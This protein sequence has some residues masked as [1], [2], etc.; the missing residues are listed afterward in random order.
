VAPAVGI[1][2]QETRLPDEVVVVLVYGEV[3]DGFLAWQRS[4]RNHPAPVPLK[5][6][7]LISHPHITRFDPGGLRLAA[8]DPEGM[9]SAGPERIMFALDAYLQ[10]RVLVQRSERRDRL[11][12]QLAGDRVARDDLVAHLDLFN[13][14]V[15]TVGTS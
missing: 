8:F 13:R 12:F 14:N 6:L 3:V 5:G 15:A 2:Y 11:R 4:D 1:V 9:T 10:Q 7:E